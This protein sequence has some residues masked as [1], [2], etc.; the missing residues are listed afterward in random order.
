MNINIK[1]TLGGVLFDFI[2]IKYFFFLCSQR[3]IYLNKKVIFEK[4]LYRFIY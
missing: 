1:I 4:K 2:M 3:E